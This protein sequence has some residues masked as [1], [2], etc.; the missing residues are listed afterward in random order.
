MEYIAITK[1]LNGY[2]ITVWSNGRA[3]KRAW[4]NC[5]PGAR[6]KADIYADY[7]RDD[8]GQRGRI[9]WEG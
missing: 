6:Q 9:I 3:I 7:Y 8:N 4:S 5:E 1:T 2:D